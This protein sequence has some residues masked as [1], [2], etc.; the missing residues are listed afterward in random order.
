MHNESPEIKDVSLLNHVKTYWVIYIFIANIIMTYTLYGSR[1]TA[2]EVR[3]DK[4]DAVQTE[5]NNVELD[6]RTRLAS[7]DTTLQFLKANQQK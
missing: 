4:N 5:Q 6:I 2:L 7:I 1:L 3:A